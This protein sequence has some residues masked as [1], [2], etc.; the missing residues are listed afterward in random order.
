MVGALATVT[1]GPGFGTACVQDCLSSH[2]STSVTPL[3]VHVGFLTVTSPTRPLA[4][5]QPL[6][7]LQP[8]QSQLHNIKTDLKDLLVAMIIYLSYRL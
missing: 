4:K 8:L 7:F 2:G 1:Q 6:P 3:S 5:G